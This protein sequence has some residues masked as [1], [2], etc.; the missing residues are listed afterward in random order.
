MIV[1]MMEPMKPAEIKE[2]DGSLKGMQK[3]VGGSIEL[4][5]PFKTESIGII[6]NEEGKINYLPQ[7]RMVMINNRVADV[8]CGTA[9]IVGLGDDGEFA[10]LTDDQIKQWLPKIKTLAIWC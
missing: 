3:I 2:I 5:C 10:D 9:F 8:L 1:I 7:N 6:V 4:Y